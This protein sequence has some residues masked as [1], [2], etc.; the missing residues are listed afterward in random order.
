MLLFWFFTHNTYQITYFC[1]K[2]RKNLSRLN[3]NFFIRNLQMPKKHHF[4]TKTY[5]F[6]P[7]LYSRPAQKLHIFHLR[8]SGD[9][10]KISLTRLRGGTFSPGSVFEKW[11]NSDLLEQN[12]LFSPKTEVNTNKCFVSDFLLTIL[13]KSRI[14][15]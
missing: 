2:K 1:L 10:K 11:P 15:V 13:I 14:W 5:F 6:D 9:Q 8:G 12:A 4:T 7:P 3:H